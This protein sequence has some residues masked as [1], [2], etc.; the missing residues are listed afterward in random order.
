MYAQPHP[1]RC[2]LQVAHAHAS[3]NRHSILLAEEPDRLHAM[4]AL[5]SSLEPANC[6]VMS[7]LEPE[8]SRPTP[9]RKLV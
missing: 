5:H 2:S 9:L 6:D 8:Q 4:S 3:Q 1:D 7:L